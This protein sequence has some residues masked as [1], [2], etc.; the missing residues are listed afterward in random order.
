VREPLRQR[1]DAHTDRGAAHHN[2]NHAPSPAS[3]PPEALM[4][5]RFISPANMAQAI[6]SR[7]PTRQQFAS[8]VIPAL[9]EAAAVERGRSRTGKRP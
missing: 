8:E 7:P 1:L 2:K 3:S 9:R 5:V 4:R 6:A